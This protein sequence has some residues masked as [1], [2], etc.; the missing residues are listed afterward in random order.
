MPNAMRIVLARSDDG[1]HLLS[2][3]MDALRRKPHVETELFAVIPE[4][5]LCR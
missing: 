3:Q 2:L 1:Q 4:V 5:W